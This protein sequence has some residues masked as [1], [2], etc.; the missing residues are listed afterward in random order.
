MGIS[1]SLVEFG[2][3]LSD[4]SDKMFGGGWEGV[5]CGFISGLVGVS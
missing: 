1:S 5:W 3:G 2:K 4:D